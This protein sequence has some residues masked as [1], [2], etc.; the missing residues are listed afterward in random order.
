MGVEVQLDTVKT[1]RSLYVIPRG[2]GFRYSEISFSI[3]HMGPVIKCSLWYS[4]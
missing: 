4:H 2:V 3:E 1:L